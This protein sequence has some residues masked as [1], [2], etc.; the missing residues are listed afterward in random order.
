M[1]PAS[2]ATRASRPSSTTWT[3]PASPSPRTTRPARPGPRQKGYLGY[4]S[5][6]SLDDLAQRDSLFADLKK[7]LDK[8][9]AA[10]AK[11]LNLDLAGG[12]LV[13]DSFWI[14]IL[15]PGGQH[16]GHIHPHSV[17]SGTVYVTIPPGASALKFEDPRLP[18]M[19]AAP[20][21]QADAPE[22]LQPFVYV[23]PEP[24][25]VLMWESWLRHEVTPNAG[26]GGADQPQLQLRLAVAAISGGPADPWRTRP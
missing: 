2:P 7:K 4:T 8:H 3:T 18:M 15:E 10:F 6:A 17:I 25:T 14:N 16:S 1:K 21:R 20:T 19:M 11:D 26:R 22:D 13:M 9:A 24:G 5:Y 12:K 23:Q